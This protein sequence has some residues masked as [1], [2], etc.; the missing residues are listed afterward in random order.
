MSNEVSV[1]NLIMVFVFQCVVKRKE[2]HVNVVFG[3]SPLA[4]EPFKK[5]DV[6]AIITIFAL[7]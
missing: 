3:Q 6:K 4:V 5:A 1:G 7:R 2:F